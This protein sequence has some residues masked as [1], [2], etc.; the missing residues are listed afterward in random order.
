MKEPLQ[1]IRIEWGDI[2]F[3]NGQYF[4]ESAKNLKIRNFI[5]E[6][7]LIEEDNEKVII[8]LTIEIDGEEGV[9]DVYVFPRGCIKKLS[10]Y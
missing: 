9:I 4:E 6:G 7:F 5:T 2:T 8:A 10:Y 3:Y 1:K